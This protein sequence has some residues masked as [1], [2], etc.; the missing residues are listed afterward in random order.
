MNHLLASR[1]AKKKP[2]KNNA[3][4]NQ[5]TPTPQHYFSA[6]SFLHPPRASLSFVRVL[7]SR[8]RP[9]AGREPCPPESHCVREGGRPG[10]GCAVFSPR[11]ASKFAV[12]FEKGTLSQNSL[13]IS[14][15]PSTKRQPVLEARVCP[16]CKRS[17]AWGAA[18]APSLPRYGDNPNLL[19]GGSQRQ[20][21]F[22]GGGRDQR[23][24]RGALKTYCQTRRLLVGQKPRN[25]RQVCPPPEAL[26]EIQGAR[27]AACRG[28]CP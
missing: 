10:V 4:R 2:P 3:E 7:V 22:A 15:L 5:T 11:G 16:L 18:N 28:P 23:S 26:A 17:A 12:S 6:A 9:A 21:P 13:Q 24:R 14:K 19:N 20:A 1:P 25:R 8:A 27:L